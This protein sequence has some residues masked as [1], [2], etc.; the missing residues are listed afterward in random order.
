[1]MLPSV[2]N[3][4]PRGKKS[5]SDHVGDQSRQQMGGKEGRDE[6]E[7]PRAGRQGRWSNLRQDS[8]SQVICK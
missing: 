3:Q 5:I 1:M 8:R 7:A 4:D 6:L 2:K